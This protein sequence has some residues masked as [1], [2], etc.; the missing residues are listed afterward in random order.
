[1]SHGGPATRRSHAMRHVVPIEMG[2]G[3][4]NTQL[5]TTTRTHSDAGTV[6]VRLCVCTCLQ[7]ARRAVNPGY[8]YHY[9]RLQN[10]VGFSSVSPVCKGMRDRIATTTKG[11]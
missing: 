10:K 3:H 5:Y 4:N 6:L 8:E 11:S 2:E 9:C 7:W 1:M